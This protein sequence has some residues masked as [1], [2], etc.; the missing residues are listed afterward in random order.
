MSALS[1]TDQDSASHSVTDLSDGVASVQENK[2]CKENDR[3]ATV[4]A[5]DQS[6]VA[7]GTLFPEQVPNDSPQK[8]TILDQE[9]PKAR[10][11]SDKKSR[12]S[13]KKHHQAKKARART[14]DSDNATGVKC[15]SLTFNLSTLF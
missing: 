2:M 14:S 7:D 8:K 6:G 3:D 10:S 5:P 15:I 13:G 1:I 9:V 4:T 12:Q 11:P